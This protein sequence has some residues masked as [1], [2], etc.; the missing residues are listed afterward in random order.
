MIEALDQPFIQR[1]LA[2]G[3]LVGALG[4][5]FGVFVVQRG[6]SFLGDGLAH[7]AFGGVA[8]GLLLGMEPL[9]VAVPFTVAVALGIS[10]VRERT[11]LGADTAIGIF[12]SVSV[13]LGV[14]FLSMTGRY[15]A[16]AFTFLFGSILAVSEAD[17]LVMSLVALA[18][19]LGWRLW[20]RWA[21]ATFDRE[22]ALADHLPVVR[23]DYFLTAYIAVAIV[24]GVKLVGIILITAFLVIPA[25][26]AHLFA[27]SFTGMTVL[28]E[29]LSVTSS[30]VG[31]AL[32]YQLDIPSGATIILV[33]AAS[34]FASMALTRV[35]RHP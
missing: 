21:Y 12:F 31:L 26:T 28:A 5:Y 10:W 7:A 4:S 1:A 18:T 15:T 3:I 19:A 11:R 22:L 6:L 14:V 29:S 33:Q 2:A 20:G 13:A 16:D 23:D 17:L 9:W 30:L 27:R 25:A 35:V 24:V 34:F 32:S 8:L